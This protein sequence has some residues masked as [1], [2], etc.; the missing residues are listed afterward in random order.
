ML[1]ISIQELQSNIIY[2]VFQ[3]FN[4]RGKSPLHNSLKQGSSN[5]TLEGQCTA[6]SLIRFGAKLCIGPP[7]VTFEEPWFTCS[8]I[9]WWKKTNK[10]KKRW[11]GNPASNASCRSEIGLIAS[12]DRWL[13]DHAGGFS[14]GVNWQIYD[15]A[16]WAPLHRVCMIAKSKVN[17]EHSFN[18]DLYNLNTDSAKMIYNI[19]KFAGAVRH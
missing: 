14:G 16:R 19:R 5:L 10:L 17:R 6:E 18:R 7:S 8:P 13:T 3:I 11:L 15:L 1:N 12:E 9:L 2:S 4:P